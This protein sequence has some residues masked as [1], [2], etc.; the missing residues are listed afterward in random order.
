MKLDTNRLHTSCLFCDPSIHGQAAQVLLKSDNFYM[1]AGLG[2][3][4]EGYLIITPYTCKSYSRPGTTLAELSYDLLDE[5][6][7][8]RGMISAFYLETYGHPGLSFE[9][10]RAGGCVQST[11]DTKHCYH[12]HLCCYPGIVTKGTGFQ[13]HKGDSVHLWDHFAL[14][15]RRIG[16]GVHSIQSVAGTLPYLFIEHYDIGDGTG[17]S[18]MPSKSRVFLAPEDHA[19]ASQFL[20]RKLADL[21]KDEGKW[22]WVTFPTEDRV[23]NVSHAFSNWLKVHSDDYGIIIPIEGGPPSLRFETS[24]SLLTAHSY[25]KIGGKFKERWQGTLQYNTIGH[26]LSH[27]PSRSGRGTDESIRLMDVGCGPGLYTKV[28]ADLGFECMAIDPSKKMLQEAEKYLGDGMRVNAVALVQARVEDVGSVVTGPFDAIWFSA[29]L[30]H[31]PRRAAGKVLRLLSTLLTEHGILYLS[32]RLVCNDSGHDFA[33]LE[34]RREGRVFVY[35]QESELEEL[36][37]DS[38]LQIV[39]SWKGMTTIGTLGEKQ[40][41]PWCHYLLR[42]IWKP[43]E[44]SDECR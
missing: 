15:N 36:F 5:L 44:E 29:V 9:H 40:N 17:T 33:A 1:F 31:I 19:L 14:P 11:D 26:F 12:P 41:K 20:R 39:K 4:I 6:A 34:I 42:K 2:A 25:E 10:G 30:L 16:N 7:F 8:L 3:I 28:F 37:A 18:G 32:T 23:R 35:Y 24:V 13:N 43:E 22:D 27:L 21:V 38:S